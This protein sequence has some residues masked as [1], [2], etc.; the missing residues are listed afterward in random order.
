MANEYAL[1]GKAIANH[2]NDLIAGDYIKNNYFFD[3]AGVIAKHSRWLLLLLFI[4]VIQGL[5]YKLKHRSSK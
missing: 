2:A 3:L 4:P 1:G 5:L